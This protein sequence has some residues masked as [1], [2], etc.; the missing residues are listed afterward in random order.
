M[1]FAP[2]F[3]EEIPLSGAIECNE[4]AEGVGVNTING[5]RDQQRLVSSWRV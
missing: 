1:G 5:A 4:N 3:I 2:L